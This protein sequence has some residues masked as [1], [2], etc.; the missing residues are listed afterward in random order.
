MVE[1]LLLFVAFLL[2]TFIYVT[3]AGYITIQMGEYILK[4][5]KKLETDIFKTNS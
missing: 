2:C 5:I 4:R 3:I 1:Y